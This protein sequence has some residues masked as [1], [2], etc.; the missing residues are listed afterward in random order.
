[1]HKEMTLQSQSKKATIYKLRRENAFLLL[2]H[3]ICSPVCGS[4]GKLTQDLS[5]WDITSS[6]F[7]PHQLPLPS[8]ASSLPTADCILLWYVMIV[9]SPSELLAQCIGIAGF[10]F[11]RLLALLL[12][13]GLCF[14]LNHKLHKQGPVSCSPDHPQCLAQR[15]THSRHSINS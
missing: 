15:L 2:S 7:S 9:T 10:A 8:P 14:Q 12:F 6:N 4:A 13:F 3:L 11:G 1:M 5:P